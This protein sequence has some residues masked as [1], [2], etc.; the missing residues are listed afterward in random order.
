MNETIAAAA[1]APGEA[2][3]GIIRISGENA[4]PLLEEIFQPEGTVENLDSHRMYYGQVIDRKKDLTID[5]CMA[6]FMKAPRSYT[7]EDVAEM[8]ERS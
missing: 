8:D 1:T 6:V 5:E 7:M 3:I 4:L 2:G